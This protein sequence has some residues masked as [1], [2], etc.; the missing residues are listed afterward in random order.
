MRRTTQL[1]HALFLALL[2]AVGVE[3]AW[4]IAATMI[5]EGIPRQQID[6]PTENDPIRTARGILIRYLGQ[7]MVQSDG[8][9]LVGDASYRTAAHRRFHTLDLQPITPRG[10]ERWLVS[11]ELLGPL[12][13]GDHFVRPG[14]WERLISVPERNPGRE[15]WYFVHDGRQDG[16]GYFAG[17]ELRSKLALGFIGKDGYSTDVP[18]REEC[19]EVDGRRLG[20][21]HEMLT[22]REQKSLSTLPSGDLPRK[23]S[24]FLPE[25]V[26]FFASGGRIWKIDMARR[27]VAPIT[28]DEGIVSFDFAGAPD[29]GQLGSGEAIPEA[30]RLV[31][32]TPTKV[33]LLNLDGQREMTWP[34]PAE[35]RERDILGDAIG[36]YVLDDGCAIVQRLQRQGNG[37]Y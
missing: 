31:A 22:W 36:W 25:A 33:I 11:A 23:A 7:I 28:E 20:R 27:A 8:T 6:L 2:V 19:F 12:Q 13:P 4:S 21:M 32:R 10:K 15:A 26:H 17:Y 24:P 9:V 37:P 5:Y 30:A 29:A 16:R 14:W 35:L 18:P 3:I 1:L 34:L